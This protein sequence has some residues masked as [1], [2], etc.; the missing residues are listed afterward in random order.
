MGIFNPKRPKAEKI[1]SKERYCYVCHR[2]L[3]KYLETKEVDDGTDEIYD[4]CSDCYPK[5]AVELIAKGAKK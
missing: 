1:L 2:K 5:M 4:I 3:G